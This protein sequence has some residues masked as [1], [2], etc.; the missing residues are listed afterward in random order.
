MDEIDR[1]VDGMKRQ[2]VA[3][4]QAIGND[5]AG[6]AA[7]RAP[8]DEGTLRGAANVEVRALPDGATLEVSFA[9]P[10]AAR[11]HE[12]LGWE[13]PKGGEAKY[14]EGPLLERAGRYERV[15]GLAVGRG[16]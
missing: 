6:E 5:L 11:Q 16:I 15:L 4:L 1:A 3:A 9:L 8:I 2:G 13:H 12:E 7:R 10:Y 14:L